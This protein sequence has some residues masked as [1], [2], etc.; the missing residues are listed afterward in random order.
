MPRVV[1]FT[2]TKSRMV[3]A[4]DWRESGVWSCLMSIVSVLQDEKRSG[5]RLHS[6]V[7]VFNTTGLY[8]KKWLR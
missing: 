8:L 2:E 1:K 6:N 7:N 4:R 3:G 5:D